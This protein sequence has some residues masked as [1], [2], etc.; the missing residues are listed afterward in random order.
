[1][2]K[3]LILLAFVLSC[4]TLSVTAQTNQNPLMD[5]ISPG[6]P[7]I[8]NQL[9]AEQMPF[10]ITN[11]VQSIDC[12]VLE[13][14]MNFV[15]PIESPRSVLFVFSSKTTPVVFVRESTSWQSNDTIIQYTQS[16]RI[17]NLDTHY[18]E[19]IAT[20]YRLIS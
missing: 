9:A 4:T 8:E 14:E 11:D 18:I 13:N 2:K 16:K 3:G 6:V 7:T 19:G 17:L 20:E 1:M 5:E 12:V 10:V 15:S